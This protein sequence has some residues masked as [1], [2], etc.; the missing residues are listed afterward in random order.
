MTTIHVSQKKGA[1]LNTGSKRY[2]LTTIPAA[3]K[4][5]VPG[6][7]V[8]IGE[9]RYPSFTIRSLHGR[10]G[11]EI[12]IQG[13]PGAAQP[14]IDAHQP[15]GKPGYVVHFLNDGSYINLRHLTITTSDPRLAESR[16]MDITTPDG[17]RE[18]LKIA[19]EVTMRW[20]DGIRFN[21]SGKG[22]T[23]NRILVENCH[24]HDLPSCALSGQLHNSRIQHCQFEHCGYPGSGYG[25][26]AEQSNGLSIVDNTIHDCT[27]WGVTVA[28]MH[29]C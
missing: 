11:Q 26:Y 14:V 4:Q 22:P 12:T 20:G 16:A 15:G 8:E 5:A 19:G 9:G 23:F 3:I 25:I 1:K 6:D 10:R 29:R 7:T 13:E 28:G 24:V 17:L 27:G 2:P 21:R 18:W